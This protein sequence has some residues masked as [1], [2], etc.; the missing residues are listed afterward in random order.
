MNVKGLS[1]IS[2]TPEIS[3]RAARLRASY[4]LRTPDAIQMAT[5]LE[6]GAAYFLTNDT[7]LQQISGIKT[8]VVEKLRKG[9]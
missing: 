4:P 6:M 5:A 2:L 7:N 3:E 9:P 1:V 8:L